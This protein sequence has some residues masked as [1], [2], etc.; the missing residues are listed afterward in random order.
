MK[1]IVLSMASN[2]ELIF[3]IGKY[4]YRAWVDTA[5]YG[6]IKKHINFKPGMVINFIK[7]RWEV[8]RY[9]II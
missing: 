8:N 2:G 6:W 3:K 1:V 7:K 5:Y 9:E 4:T